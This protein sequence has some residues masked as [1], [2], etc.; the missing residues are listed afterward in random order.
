MLK[1]I[2]SAVRDQFSDVNAETLSFIRGLQSNGNMVHLTFPGIDQQFMSAVLSCQ[3]GSFTLDGPVPSLGM[4]RLRTI[5][6]V[7]LEA[8]LGGV[9]LVLVAK[10][11]RI[12]EQAGEPVLELFYPERFSFNQ[13][14]RH[15]R[16]S[17]RIPADTE[18]RIINHDR[19]PFQG[20]LQDLSP[21]GMGL[22][23]SEIDGIMPGQILPFCQVKLPGGRTIGVEVEVRYVQHLRRLDKSRVGVQFVDLPRQDEQKIM[24]ALQRMR[25]RH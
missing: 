20:I 5:R 13:R 10:V 17:P 6:S 21:G 3:R 23:F 7:R 19:Q 22:L 14:R 25:S 24:H 18:V 2:V 1:R 11:K 8:K 4:A 15:P 9:P 12:D 16:L